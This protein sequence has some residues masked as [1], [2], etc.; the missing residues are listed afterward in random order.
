MTH[1]TPTAIL[2][3]VS[4]PPP[5]KSVLR[6]A[7]KAALLPVTLAWDR[8]VGYRQTLEVERLH[9]EIALLEDE[10]EIKSAREALLDLPPRPVKKSKAGKKKRKR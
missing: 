10:L 9:R 6:R 5:R 2:G 3:G 1:A 7:G 4:D 8:V